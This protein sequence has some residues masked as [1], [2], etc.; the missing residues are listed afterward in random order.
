MR[1]K[2]PRRWREGRPQAPQFGLIGPAISYKREIDTD[3]NIH[4]SALVS[5]PG[6]PSRL[7]E[8]ARGGKL[9]LGVSDAVLDEVSKVLARVFVVA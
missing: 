5:R 2:E 6:N 9:R 4:V 3:S 7:I 1:Q 8:L